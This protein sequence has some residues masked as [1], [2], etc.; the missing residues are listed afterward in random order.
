MEGFKGGF[1]SGGQVGV[2]VEGLDRVKNYSDGD[3]EPLMS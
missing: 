1:D 2:L 3:S